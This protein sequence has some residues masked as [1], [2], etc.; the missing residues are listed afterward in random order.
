M[1]RWQGKVGPE[2][3]RGTRLGTIACPC[4]DW[5]ASVMLEGHAVSWFG[6]LM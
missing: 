6:A 3:V 5:S 4:V 1:V 2:D